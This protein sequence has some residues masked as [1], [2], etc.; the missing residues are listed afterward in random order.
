[1]TLNPACFVP[2]L[3]E[4]RTVPRFF[5]RRAVQLHSLV[6]QPG[7]DVGQSIQAGQLL[8]QVKFADGSSTDLLAPDGCTGVIDDFGELQRDEVPWPP[9]RLILLLHDPSAPG[10][11]GARGGARRRKRNPPPTGLPRRRR[12]RASPKGTARK[13]KKKEKKQA[14]RKTGRASR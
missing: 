6:W 9:S 14:T 8:A 7:I 13:R 5:A 11:H 3:L 1:M 2:E 10:V 4:L 12:R